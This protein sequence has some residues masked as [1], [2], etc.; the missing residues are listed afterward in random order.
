MDD[1]FESYH[2][3]NI[4]SFYESHLKPN[5]FI[6]SVSISGS[7]GYYQE[8]LIREIFSNYSIELQTVIERPIELIIEHFCTEN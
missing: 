6:S 1:I 2:R 5:S 4:E 7:Y 8:N 3:R